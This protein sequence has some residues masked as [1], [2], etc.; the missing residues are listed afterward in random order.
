MDRIQSSQH[1]ICSDE[2]HLHIKQHCDNTYPSST[3]NT[4]Q[5]CVVTRTQCI[6]QV[7]GRLLLNF[8]IEQRWKQLRWMTSLST[9]LLTNVAKQNH[10]HDVQV[11]GVGISGNVHHS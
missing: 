11:T 10:I 4:E 2:F 9:N 7:P 5:K 6:R 8:R 3:C 1:C